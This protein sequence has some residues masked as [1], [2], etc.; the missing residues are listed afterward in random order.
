[1][2]E[3]LK[4]LATMLAP[5]LPK[6]NIEGEYQEDLIRIIIRITLAEENILTEDN[7]SEYVESYFD[8][9]FDINDYI[10][11]DTRVRDEVKDALNNVEI[12]LEL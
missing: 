11:F 4:M 7:V 5:H 8:N 2:D 9:D 10:D 12:S 3:L 6:E 1:M